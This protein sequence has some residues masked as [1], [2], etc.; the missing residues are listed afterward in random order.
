MKK[1]ILFSGLKRISMVVLLLLPIF[2]SAQTA[3]PDLPAK[4]DFWEKT[5]VGGGIALNVGSGYTDITLAPGAIYNFNRYV[6]AGLGLQGTYVNV[7][8][9]YESYIYG[10]SVIG[11]FNPV[12][13]VQLSVE[14]EELRVSSR[15][16]EI[17]IRKNFWNTALFFGAGFH[18]DNVTLGVRFN[19]LYDKNDF[20]YSDAFM[21]FIRVYF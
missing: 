21:P 3:T 12:E 15:F 1:G 18:S 19:V 11:L 20:V 2:I 10:G 14:L 7:R 6:A 17:D 16:P 13:Q 5:Q 8:D 4:K 9:R